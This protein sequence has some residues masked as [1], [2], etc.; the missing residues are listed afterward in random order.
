MASEVS[1]VS[2]EVFMRV[3]CRDIGFSFKV[4]LFVATK[5]LGIVCHQLLSPLSLVYMTTSSK[6]L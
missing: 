3:H 4:F 5:S 1:R 2:E 6:Y